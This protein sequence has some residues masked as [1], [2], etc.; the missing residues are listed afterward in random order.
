MSVTET[1]TAKNT[2]VVLLAMLGAACANGVAI[3]LYAHLWMRRQAKKAKRCALA[4]IA[5][6][7]VCRASPYG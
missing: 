1:Y 7:A 4:R 2:A 3:S 5:L 6:Q